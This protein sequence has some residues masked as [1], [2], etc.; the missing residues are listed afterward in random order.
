MRPTT[1]N[2]DRMVNLLL[3]IALGLQ[4][5]RDECYKRG[6]ASHWDRLKTHLVAFELCVFDSI[7]INLT[8]DH[9]FSSPNESSGGYFPLGTKPTGMKASVA[10]TGNPA[11]FHRTD[12]KHN[13]LI[14]SADIR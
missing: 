11:L 10:H 8:R 14:Q 1:F 12:F 3:T 13:L 2:T 6:E 4:S 7:L 9:F 5:K